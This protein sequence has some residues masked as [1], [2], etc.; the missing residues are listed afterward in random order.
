[1]T[2]SECAVLFVGAL[3]AWALQGRAAAA[4]ADAIYTRPGRIVPAGDGARLNLYC[5]G[6]G[7]PTVVFESGWED[8]A[9]AWATVQ[10]RV[11]QWARACSRSEERR[12]AKEC[13]YR[14]WADARTKRKQV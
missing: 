10:P 11:A 14:W 2:R 5:M 7:A 3:A 1:M 9:P 12:V 13:R 8:W 4:P 6:N